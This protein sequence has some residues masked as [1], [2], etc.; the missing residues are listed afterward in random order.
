MSQQQQTPEEAHPE[1]TPDTAFPGADDHFKATM[2]DYDGDAF[3]APAE[4]PVESASEEQPEPE[5]EAAQATEDEG[6]APERSGEPSPE[7]AKVRATAALLGA[8]K[9]WLETATDEEITEW[10]DARAK[11]DA[12]VK[13]AFRENAE[14]RR[15]LEELKATKEAEPAVPTASEDQALIEALERDLD[16]ETAKMLAARLS[17]RDSEAKE[18][19]ARVS[20]LEAATEQR[21]A[22]TIWK[23]VS[24]KLGIE[25]KDGTFDRV[26][27]QAGE[28]AKGQGPWSELQGDAKAE[29]LF[30]AAARVAMPDLPSDSELKRRAAISAARKNGTSTAAPQRAAPTTPKTPDEIADEKLAAIIGRGERDVDK[31]RA[32]R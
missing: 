23:D 14:Y 25:E 9:K 16:P 28:L 1:V 8:P 19:M 11:A 30:T 10:T 3:D 29:A 21:L 2:D 32:I 31:L 4:A 18:R 20:A 17:A 15:E 27:A 5:P 12:D 13:R 6:A 7:T 22:K 24:Q 26:L